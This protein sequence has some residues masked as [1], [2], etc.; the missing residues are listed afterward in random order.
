MLLVKASGKGRIAAFEIMVATD[1]IR[2]LIRDGKTYRITSDIQTGAK[3]GMKT[4]DSS[5]LELYRKNL[6]SYEDLLTKSQ[7]PE[8]IV[9]KLKMAVSE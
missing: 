2:A 5:L 6:I 8:A 4:L 9:T 7:D 1:S 3:W